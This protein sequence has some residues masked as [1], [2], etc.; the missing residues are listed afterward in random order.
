[1]SRVFVF[2]LFFSFF[3]CVQLWLL[4]TCCLP[5]LVKSLLGAGCSLGNIRPAADTVKQHK[6]D[7][8]LLELRILA[9]CP[10]PVMH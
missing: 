10:L 4:Y 6:N 7:A 8:D 5:N 9:A 1:M 2:F 3:A